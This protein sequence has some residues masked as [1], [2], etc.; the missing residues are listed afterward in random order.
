M[1]NCVHNDGFDSQGWFHGNSASAGLSDSV[2][3]Y[4]LCLSPP[5]PIRFTAYFSDALFICFETCTPTLIPI[6]NAA[7]GWICTI[8]HFSVHTLE[9]SQ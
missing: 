9:D 6:P 1:F 2:S 5:L 3:A 7:G 8:E 4:T